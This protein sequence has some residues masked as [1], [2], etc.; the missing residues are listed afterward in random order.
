[1]KKGNSI[2]KPIYDF[3]IHNRK[4][5]TELIF[6]RKIIIIEGI[7]ALVK[8][9]IRELGDAKVFIK[10]SAETRLIRRLKKRS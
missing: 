5:E 8:K 3:T 1:M 4:E 7:M 2:N 9:E 10:A 6:P